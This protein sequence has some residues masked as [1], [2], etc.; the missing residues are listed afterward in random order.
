MAAQIISKAVGIDLGTTNSAVAIMNATDLDIILH[1]DLKTKAETTPSCVWKDPK[2]GE[3]VVG[4]LAFRRAGT[5]PLP[6]R[7]AKRLMGSSS[8]IRMTD[9]DVTPEQV[10]AYILGEMRR[11]IEEDVARMA[12]DSTTWV[13]DRA[14]I[15]VP[16]YFDTPSIEATR[17]A[18]EMA[19][20]QV[21]DLL[22]EPSAAA[23]YHCWRTGTQNGV[24]LVYDFGGGTFDVSVL[25]CTA[26][27]FEVL[28]ISGNNLLGGDNID[29]ALA[30]YL[31][32]RLLREDYALELDTQNDPEDR[33]RFDQL[34]FLGE[35]IKK[36]LSNS[37]EFVLR[38]SRTLQD[39]AGNPVIIDTMFELPEI[40]EIMRPIIERTLPYCDEALERAGKKAG[41]TLADIDEVILAGGSTHIPL[42]REMVRQKLCADPAATEPRAKCA[43]PVYEKVDTIV[44]LGAAIRAAA[45]GGLAVYNPERTVRVTFRGTG[46]TGAQQTH[47]GGKV[48]ANGLDLTGGRIRLSMVDT[49]YEDE[50]ELKEGGGFGFTRVPL[51]PSAENVLAFDVYDRN[52]NHV[53]TAGR[54]VSQS[55]EAHRPTGGSASTAV[56]SKAILLE[57]T[58]A[59]QLTL[60]EL[61]PALTTLPAKIEH[62]LMHPG[63]TETVLL[64]LYQQKRKIKEIKVPVPLSLPRGTPIDLNVN[65]DEFT[66]ITVDGRIGDAAFTAAVEIPP[67][68]AMPTDEEVLNLERSF[69]DA[70][71]Y[72]PSGKKAKAE[73]RYK[74]ARRSFEAAAKRGDKEQAIHDF[75]EMEE[76]VSEI[77]TGPS[78]LQPPKEVFNDLVSECHE[79][80]R[81]VARAAGEAGQPH[82]HRETEKAIEAQRVQGEKAYADDNQKA[83]SD[84]FTMLEALHNHLVA[85]GRKIMQPVDNRTDGER[86]EDSVKGAGQQADRVS[87]L[88]ASKGRKDFEDEV[89]RIKAELHDLSREAQKNPRAVQEKV[90]QLWGRL[91]QIKNF[92]M[93]KK[94]ETDE[95]KRPED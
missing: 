30:E 79:I 60:R 67:D 34:K 9:E 72:L 6:I 35:S 64:Y 65:I 41:I 61:V 29:T 89:K 31:Q 16:A 56:I 85:L 92:V 88:A 44:A 46:A 15:T 13:V 49:G 59:G 14:I 54:P 94:D 43:A 21:V 50:Q 51:Q 84:A 74:I 48:E 95:G 82:D 11:Q 19:G 3:V 55:R 37:G 5:A 36:A 71:A 40:E 33:L 20:L 8:R 62:K 1:R 90:Q 78:T 23:C 77:S 53:A 91:E 38:D 93:G 2:T 28:G 32:E 83:L 18:G 68:R 45:V 86:A 76:I 87:Q 52:G 63:D 39:K 80:N 58:R 57:V 24:F 22:H 7:S 81:H 17:R 75:E 66:F 73:I 4:R 10:S 27:A 47:I 26:G 25:R 70:V 69:K 42:V 12:T